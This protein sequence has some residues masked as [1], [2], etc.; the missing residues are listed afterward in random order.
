MHEKNKKV[1]QLNNK[2]DKDKERYASSHYTY[3]LY[4]NTINDDIYEQK[5]IREIKKK[6]FEYLFKLDDLQYLKRIVNEPSLVDY[7]SRCIMLNLTSG[8]KSDNENDND[9]KTYFSF[10]DI[11]DEFTRVQ[12]TFT[13]VN[14]NN[15]LSYNSKDYYD[16][17]DLLKVSNHNTKYYLKICGIYFLMDC[18]VYMDIN[19]LDK[20]HS[21]YLLV[22]SICDKLYLSGNTEN[23][24]HKVIK[25]ISLEK[26]KKCTRTVVIME[27]NMFNNVEI[28]DFNI[29][30]NVSLMGDGC[31]CHDCI[32]YVHD[33]IY[34][35][36]Y[37]Y[38]KRYGNKMYV[39]KQ[40][41]VYRERRYWK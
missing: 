3:S 25:G 35:S 24:E 5:R 27:D 30:N 15:K 17:S 31:C 13:F 4:N 40:N 32:L 1:R 38:Y 21:K 36:Q 26:S 7:V 6:A 39:T 16:N 28:K 20:L 8:N 10:M 11:I 12:F 9:V 18:E 23:F 2:K 33:D 29:I 19:R 22:N 14:N 41:M 34:D 37:G